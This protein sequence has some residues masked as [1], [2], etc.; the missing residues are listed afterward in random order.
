MS[1]LGARF[2]IGEI[3]GEMSVPGL[4]FGISIVKFGLLAVAFGVS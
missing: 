2:R 3:S 4:T 1:G